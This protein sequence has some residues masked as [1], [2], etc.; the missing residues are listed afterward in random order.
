M[1]IASAPLAREASG[2]LRGRLVRGAAGSFGLIVLSTGLNLATTVLLARLLGVEA[3]GIYAWVVSTVLLLGIPAVLGVDRLLIREIAVYEARGSHGLAHG[4]LRRAGISILVVSTLLALGT[5]GL[6]W[7]L[8]AGS[9]SVTLVALT[10]GLLALPLTSLIRLTQS[11]TM[12]LHHVVKAQ[13]PELLLRPLVFLASIVGA[14]LLLRATLPVVLVVALYVAAA[15]VALAWGLV[16]L[17]ARTPEAIR[18]ASPEYATRTW[19]LSALPL[20]FLTGASVINAQIGTVVLGALRSPEEAGL[21]SVAMRGAVLIAFALQAVNA[22]LG[23][24][25]ARLWEQ[26]DR[27]RLQEVV[28]SS[29]RW[30]MAFSLPA[31][32]AFVFFGRTLLTAAFGQE[33]AAADLALGIVAVGQ[34]ANAAFGSVGT[35]LIMT[36]HQRQAALGVGIGAVANA[37]L[38]FLLVPLWG[39]LGAAVAAAASLI[40]WNVLLAVLARRAIGMTSTVLAGFRR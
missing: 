26:G 1:T 38:T 14:L 27:E 29:A 5:A 21:F 37:V 17:R 39:V 34:L 33:Y 16:V 28:T 4:L 20:T 22:A 11:A 18:R 23:P 36:G 35:L 8:S 32:L 13:I 7:L 15:G 25:I 40:L 9:E 12:G 2:S 19:V 6:A 24:T 30:I 10:V 3:F 31:T